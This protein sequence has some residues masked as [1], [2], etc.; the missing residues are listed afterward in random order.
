MA[1]G[2]VSAGAVSLVCG[3]SG[4]ASCGDGKSPVL[5]VC[6]ADYHDQR[7]LDLPQLLGGH[8]GK[9]L[10]VAVGRNQLSV[11]SLEASGH[12]RHRVLSTPAAADFG[13]GVE[14]AAAAGTAAAAVADRMWDLD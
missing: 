2:L 1:E 10:G 3:S 11:H 4:A 13:M 5:S 14:A 6:P 7:R 9:R 12:Q 8:L